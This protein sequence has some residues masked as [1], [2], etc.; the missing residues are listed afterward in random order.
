MKNIDLK[1]DPLIIQWIDNI[2]KQA[3]KNLYFLGVKVYTNG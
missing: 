1:E 2:N 3:T